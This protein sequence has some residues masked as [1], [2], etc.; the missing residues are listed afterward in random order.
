[1]IVNDIS[2]VIGSWGSYNA[3]N[4]RAYGSKWLN[5][6]EYS[7]WDEIV[8][9]LEKQGINVRV[10]DIHTI[11]PIDKEIIIKSAKETKRLLS[12]EDHSIIGGL[13]AAIAEV[14]TEE[15]PCKLERMGIKDCFGKSGKA[16]ELLE[17]F[18]IDSKAIVEKFI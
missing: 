2:I 1:M 4:E 17:Y 9:E 14:L 6:S 11:K 16:E 7:D 15:Y 5:L 13:G 12:V 8:E 10:I 3:C 18:K